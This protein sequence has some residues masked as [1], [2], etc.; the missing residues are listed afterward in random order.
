MAENM[1]KG[2]RMTPIFTSAVTD[3]TRPRFH[4]ARCPVHTDLFCSLAPCL[5]LNPRPPADTD[6]SNKLKNRKTTPLDSAS[7]L[8]R[9]K[10][11]TNYTYETEEFWEGHVLRLDNA[12][13]IADAPNSHSTKSI[14][15]SQINVTDCPINTMQQIQ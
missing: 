10:D 12:H 2:R 8:L 3:N 15:E 7:P 14:L 11:K 4:N 5:W 1:P 6:A 9:P 13:L